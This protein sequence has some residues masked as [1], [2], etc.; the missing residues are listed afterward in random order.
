[1]DTIVKNNQGFSLVSGSVTFDF[2]TD[3]YPVSAENVYFVQGEGDMPVPQIQKGDRLLLPIDEGVALEAD[4]EYEPGEYGMDCIKSIFCGRVGT[5]GMVIVE[6]S[7]KFLLIMVEDVLNSYYVAEKKEGLYS[8][9]IHC[10]KPTAVTYGIFDSIKDA[11]KFYRS[12]KDKTYVTLSDKIEKNP[13]LKKMVGG[14]IFWVWN[15]NYDEIMYSDFDT[16]VS[17]AVGKDLLYVADDL[18]KNGVSNA[19][20]GIFFEKDSAL[21]EELYK[22]YGFICTQYDNYSDVLNPELLKIIPKNRVKNCDYTF[23]RMKDYPDGVVVTADNELAPAWALKGLDGIM[24]N[25]NRLC[26]I[27]AAKRMEEEIPQILNQYPYYKGR[28]IDV[29]GGGVSR[30]Y[31]KEHPLTLE[32]SAQVKNNA[33]KAIK[34]MGLI[35]GTEDIM[36]DIIDNIDYSEGLHSP[37]HFRIHDAGR[38]HAHIYSEEQTAF[39]NKYMTNPKCRVPLWQLVYHECVISFPYWGDSTEMAPDLIRDKILFAC[40]YGCAPLYSFSI[41]D[42]EKIKPAILL[43]YEKITKVHKAVAELPMTDFEI[44]SEDY[45]LQR[46]EFGG[47]YEI[48]ANFAE[49]E[50]VINNI[51]IPAKDF[52]FGIKEA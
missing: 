50:S 46:S 45:T 18:H 29:F 10:N 22:K 19:L 5:L 26:S 49:K 37:V 32:K 40:L 30:C 25:Q 21:V 51:T 6:R 36:E 8:L 14:G 31:S 3:I 23:R 42:Y 48:I 17:P 35:T 15:D 1:M 2:T 33:F 38:N 7:K 16:D 28:F 41:K 34:D 43:S 44:L 12:A 39:I 52:Y 13:E 27:V 24:H 11:C 9:S 20:F 47:K 4:E